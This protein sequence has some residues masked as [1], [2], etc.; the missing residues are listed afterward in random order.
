[1]SLKAPENTGPLCSALL[2]TK[3]KKTTPDLKEKSR[4]K[5]GKRIAI[6][7]EPRKF[8]APRTK[9]P[10]EERHGLHRNERKE[11]KK[12]GKKRRFHTNSKSPSDFFNLRGECGPGGG[13][14]RGALS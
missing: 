12:D 4:L 5:R 7:I 10:S 6:R 2:R 3:K 13:G 11:K 9:T 14:G 8:H 1:M